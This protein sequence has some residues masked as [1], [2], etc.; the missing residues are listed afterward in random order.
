VL[1]MALPSKAADGQL[2]QDGGQSEDEQ[3]KH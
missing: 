2:C 3:F 1:T